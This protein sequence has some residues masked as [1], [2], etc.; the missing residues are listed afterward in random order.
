[1]WIVPLHLHVNI[2]TDDDDD[3]D[4]TRNRTGVFIPPPNEV[5]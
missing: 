2:N 5:C 1:M 3:D 4:V